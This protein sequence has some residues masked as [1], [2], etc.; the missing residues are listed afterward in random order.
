LWWVRV[1][2]LLGTLAFPQAGW[3]VLGTSEPLTPDELLTQLAQAAE[4]IVLGTVVAKSSYYGPDLAIYTDV[5]I[6]VAADLKDPSPPAEMVVTVKGGH[7]GNTALLVSDEPTF[8]VGEQ[9]VAFLVQGGPTWKVAGFKFGKV[10]ILEGQ[11]LYFGKKMPVTD[12]LGSV[13]RA[14]QP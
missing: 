2:V 5:T 1:I 12:F 7:I 10:S 4:R 13:Q 6:R 11:V 9:V 3:A 14:L 8:T